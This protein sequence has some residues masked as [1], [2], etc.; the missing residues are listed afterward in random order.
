MPIWNLLPFGAQSVPGTAS[1]DSR[2]R[3]MPHSPRRRPPVF[4]A[5]IICHM[6]GS[7][8]AR[9][10]RMDFA[11]FDALWRAGGEKD[12]WRHP[13]YVEDVDHA[14]DVQVV[15]DLVGRARAD[16]E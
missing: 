10:F 16:A 14:I 4:G 12:G 8:Q 15:A 6:S 2:N 11:R 13:V 1:W 9:W 7:P 5:L 3:R